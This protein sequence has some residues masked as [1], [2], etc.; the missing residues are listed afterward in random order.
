MRDR[1]SPRLW[2][3]AT[4]LAVG[5]GAGTDATYIEDDTPS[6]DPFAQLLQDLSQLATPCTYN[7]S[8]RQLVVTLA[9]NEVALIKRF[10]GASA[11]A[12]DFVLVNG[13]DCNGTTVPAGTGNTP[14]QRVSVTGSTGAESVIFDFTDGMFAQGTAAT[15]GITV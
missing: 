7:S 2:G 15:N 13:F 14:V 6:D 10:P 11:P 12:D 9:A 8:G 5:C 3:T 1:F 4:I